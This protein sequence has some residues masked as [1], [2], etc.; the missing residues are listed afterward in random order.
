MR[1]VKIDYLIGH[2]QA[3]TLD[4]LRP[5]ALMLGAAMRLHVLYRL[6]KRHEPIVQIGG[7]FPKLR[8]IISLR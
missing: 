8:P 3:L 5:A 2:F 6:D 1:P 4:E 7:R